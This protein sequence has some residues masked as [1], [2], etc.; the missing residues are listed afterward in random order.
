MNC[1]IH[2]SIFP[3]YYW[4]LVVY[5]IYLHTKYYFVDFFL[6]YKMPPVVQS[7]QLYKDC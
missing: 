1:K 4:Y 3:L 5:Q 2:L 7:S 6:S